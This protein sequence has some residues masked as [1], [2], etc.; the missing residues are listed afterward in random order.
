MR[1]F[2]IALCAL[3]CLVASEPA[4]STV[5]SSTNKTI[6][7]GNGAQTQFSFSF[8][9]VATAYIS[10]LYTDASGNQTVLSQGS[11]A[12]QYQVSLNPVVQGA[13]WGLGGT[14]TYNPS[15][16]P[17]PNG[18]TLTIYRTLPLTQAVTLQNMASIAVLGKG[19]E[20]GL[21]TGVMQGQQISEQSSRA[22]V[23]NIAN[24]TSPLP[25]PPAAQLANQ[26]ICGDGTGLNLIACSI[27]SS[28]IISSAMQP[29][30]DAATLALG[31]LAFG[32]GSMAQENVN[33]GACGGATIQDDGSAG[34]ANGAGYARVVFGLTSDAINQ[35]VICAF[36]MSQRV[37]TGPITYT[38]PR[39]NTLF[40]GFGFKVYVNSGLV[41]FTPNASDNFPGV[42]SGGSVNVAAG[43][44]CTLF[45][46]AA[47]SGL[48]E[49]SCN[50]SPPS[51]S[52]SAGAN[53]LTLT[54]SGSL[55]NFRDTT[56]AN[57]DPL[58][59]IPAGL[60]SITIPSGASL[61]TSSSNVPFRVWVF[62]A[63]N[64]G[65]PVLGVATCSTRTA[66]LPC[67]AWETQRK[68]GTA[69]TSGA[70]VAGTLYTSAGVTN[71]AVRIIGYADYASGLT[72]AGTWAS[73]PTTL[74]L[75]IPPFV[76]TRP[77]SV[78]QV[79]YA[80]SQL[81][82][83]SAG[84]TPTVTDAF[85]TLVVSSTPNLIEA[86]ANGGSLQSS[87]AGYAV[88]QLYRVAGNSPSCTTAVG[89]KI[90]SGVAAGSLFASMALRALDA[91]A[92]SSQQT[93]VVCI[94]NSTANNSQWCSN[95]QGTQTCNIIVKEI[96]GALKP[97]ND[98]GIPAI[99]AAA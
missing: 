96:M 64:S 57:G 33:G 88:A 55:I 78:V 29:V 16:T 21:D 63:Y 61:G 45:T 3:A 84:S 77:G 14:V 25:L 38:L 32:L 50:N 27:P 74:Q 71:D 70:T 42:A 44:V 53:A 85:A 91:P 58:W 11:G 46:N 72:T 54:L 87:V 94:S 69:I 82:T 97:D 13:I 86:E 37:A 18:S 31:R 41:T 81:G 83:I 22:I 19:A 99:P 51:L 49:I 40:N 66:T 8:V 6:A 26:G 98:N 59:A 24:A 9:G 60:L 35:S 80:A 20:T 17:I 28:G 23:A 7:I 56:L 75:C 4:R 62:V 10:V 12:T 52:A 67:S 65:T 93:Y 39:A 30:V 34:G 47:G 89:N 43:S 90:V 79:S 68:T 36:H 2:I 5:N 15:G 76:C 95:A 73:A 92:A 1:R 48:W